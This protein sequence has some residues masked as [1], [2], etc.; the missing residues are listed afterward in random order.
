MPEISSNG[1]LISVRGARYR[2]TF[3]RTTDRF[4]LF[5]PAGRSVVSAPA[6]PVLTVTDPDGR[7][8]SIACRRI[9]VR[10]ADDAVDI[11]YSGDG[12]ERVG[13]QWRFDD[14]GIWLEP[15]TYS[16]SA[17]RAVVAVHYFSSSGSPDP[18][19]PGEPAPALRCSHLVQPGR[20]GSPALGT[21]LDLAS[22]IAVDSWLGRGDCTDPHRISQQWG[23]PSHY[24]A[25]FNLQ[26]HP[27][28][29]GAFTDKL[30]DA[31]CLGLADIPA[32]DVRTVI[33]DGRAALIFDIRDD[34]WHRHGG[35][36]PHRLGARLRWSF[37]VD[38]R[39]AI[40]AYY[41][42]LVAA[43]AIAVE[44]SGPRKAHV[45]RTSEYN[46]WGAQ[47]AHHAEADLLDQDSLERIYESVRGSSM[48]PGMFV[49]DDRW[50]SSYGLSEHDPLRLPRFEQF[51][52][53]VR[54]DG[55]LVGLWSAFLRCSDPALLGLTAEHLLRD[56]A[57]EPI[58]I[59]WGAAGRSHYLFDLS[60]PETA[61]VVSERIRA[62]VRR[63]QPDLVKF[64]F[65]YELPSIGVCQPA[66]P[67][68]AGE[69]LLYNSLR[70]IVDALRAEDP[71]I[72][73]MY[74]SLSPLYVPLIDLHSTDDI[75]QSVGQ[76]PET[77]N[78]RTFFASLLGELGVPTYGSG[79][80]NWHEIDQIWFDAAAAGPLGS[81]GSFDGDQLDTAP[82]DRQ[83]AV[84][85]GIGELTRQEPF[86]TI[87]ALDP[88]LLGGSAGGRS[89]SWARYESGR[90]VMLAL[91]TRPDADGLR[92]A[93][94]PDLL[95]STVQLV[96]ASCTDD[97]LLAAD[98]LGVVPFASGEVTLRRTGPATANAHT[99]GGAD[100][101]LELHTAADAVTLPLPVR[102]DGRPVEWI[103]IRFG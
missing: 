3:D 69:R 19:E 33:S 40:R 77:A 35:T 23:L 84:Y 20:S 13:V 17:D 88:V 71:D 89:R 39:A 72:V 103:E 18:D 93:V 54:D 50:E 12:G 102:I 37:G 94:F 82:T 27:N 74:Y 63:Y 11:D 4:E 66:D 6:Q 25:V 16:G 52:Q 73:V 26:V 86:A 58:R 47:L 87:E 98:T 31:V 9:D 81:L 59:H 53:R 62:L 28:R 70:V 34:L 48:R 61:A 97:D 49:V 55:Q 7:A 5:D 45:L 67:E 64:D 99:A 76:Y 75:W 92:S 2:W 79:G 101:P 1:A 83:L 57:G 56:R 24:F 36:G 32:A 85:N 44:R 22:K 80:Y 15:L 42:D 8:G 78:Q 29:P 90:L 51:L 100:V 60:Q 43:G 14:A 38:Y 46:P 30:S 95:T 10:V 68:W 65:G 41:R 96:I 21:V 91:R